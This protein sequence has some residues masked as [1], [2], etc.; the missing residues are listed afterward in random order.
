MAEGRRVLGAWVLM[1]VICAHGVDGLWLR[2]PGDMSG[3]GLQAGGGGRE[4]GFN[5]G[6]PYEGRGTYLGGILPWPA[7]TDSGELAS[8][9]AAMNRAS[10]QSM[11]GVPVPSRRATRVGQALLWARIWGKLLLATVG[12][13]VNNAD[14]ASGQQH[15][16]SD[17]VPF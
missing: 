17:D 6:K 8:D 15:F 14:T 12:L 4:E 10:Q 5:G 16:S 7:F 11:A 3:G 2:M 1:C 13:R 9:V